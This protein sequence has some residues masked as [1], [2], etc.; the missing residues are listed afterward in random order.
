ME[1]NADVIVIGSGVIGSSVAY[2]L[3][4]K[5][6]SVLMLEAGTLGCGASSACDGFVIL[7][8]KSP[9]PHLTMALA[10]EILY[11]TLSEELDYDIGYSH[12]GGMIII[13][14]EEELEAMKIFMSKQK[15]LGLD[16]SLISGDEARIVEPALSKHIVGATISTRDA[17]VNPLYMVNG[18]IT[19]AKRLGLRVKKHKKATDFIRDK[20]HVIGVRCG[21][22]SLYADNVVVCNSIGAPELF[23]KIGCELPI[24][25]RRGQL[26]ITEPVNPLIYHVMLC[27]RYIAAKYHPELL[28]GSSDESIRLGVGMALEQTAEGGLLIGSTREFVGADRS[29][30]VAGVRAVTQHAARIVPALKRIRAVRTFAGLRPYTPDGK[31]FMRAV[32]EHKGLFIA[33]GHEGD[34]IAYAP[35]TG[36][37]IAEL[38]VDGSTGVDLTPFAVDRK[39]EKH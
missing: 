3:T 32:P 10:S 31:A 11:R 7:Q 28:E 27:S 36:K 29:T 25:P 33:A 14:R 39:I 12:C 6:A 22:D 26:V 30:T 34:G 23:A 24:I 4:K 16:V 17:Q 5:G 9:G 35:I 2:N 15:D 18:Y 20:E 1:K 19:A 38:V 8:S 37:T 21:G 13:E